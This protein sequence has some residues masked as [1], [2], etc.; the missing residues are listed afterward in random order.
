MDTA[1]PTVGARC[2]ATRQCA[3]RGCGAEPERPAAAAPEP[4][5]RVARAAFTLL[6]LLLVIVILGIVTAVVV[7]QFG[8]AMTGGQLRVAARAIV[9]ASRYARTMALLHQLETELVLDLQQ[10]RVRVEAA[11]ATGEHRAVGADMDNAGLLAAG[12][13][14]DPAL[15]PDPAA[16]GPVDDAFAGMGV[17]VV[18]NP[19]TLTSQSL[20][21]E[22][23]SEFVCEGNTFTF[24]GYTEDS[25]AVSPQ[26]EGQV[27]IRFRSNGTCRPFRVR[28]QTS[29]ADWLDIAIDITGAAQV[30]EPSA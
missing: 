8:A 4:R 28:V 7:P 2:G 5:R 1:W 26:A 9:Q 17:P 16:G 27:R 29:E 30:G 6:E 24:L 3:S 14:G 19:A 22:I 20:A 10:G 12:L 25:A 15:T 18:A 23:K 13:L 11:P 21:D